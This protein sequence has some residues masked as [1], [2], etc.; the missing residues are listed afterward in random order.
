MG[1]AEVHPKPVVSCSV[2]M[3]LMNV[4]VSD[5]LGTNCYLSEFAFSDVLQGMAALSTAV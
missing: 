3:A 5:V 4:Y 1:K 2:Y